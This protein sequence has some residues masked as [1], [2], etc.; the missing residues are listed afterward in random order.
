MGA[1]RRTWPCQP[2]KLLCGCCVCW[3]DPG[4]C[5]EGC[6]EL[7]C[8]FLGSL[9]VYVLL[10]TIYMYIYIYIYLMVLACIGMLQIFSVCLASASSQVSVLEHWRRPMQGFCNYRRANVRRSDCEKPTFPKLFQV[11]ST[12]QNMGAQRSNIVARSLDSMLGL[13]TTMLCLCPQKADIGWDLSVLG[14]PLISFM[15]GWICFRQEAQLEMFGTFQLLD[16]EDRHLRTLGQLI[17]GDYVM[18]G[19]RLLSMYFKTCQVPYSLRWSVLFW[20]VTCEC[21]YDMTSM[22][23]Q[24]SCLWCQHLYQASSDLCDLQDGSPPQGVRRRHTA[25]A[26]SEP[27]FAS[28][29]LDLLPPFYS[30]ENGELDFKA[31]KIIVGATW[32]HILSHI[33]GESLAWSGG[34][35]AVPGW[36]ALRSPP[37]QE[38]NG[39]LSL[40]CIGAEVQFLADLTQLI[41]R[42]LFVWF[43]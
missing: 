35:G 31:F 3:T 22:R 14:S 11:I 27:P 25:P 23:N 34:F 36:G 29:A 38:P 15:K 28:F 1:L 5:T 42:L 6:G 41:V 8:C 37:L 43:I 17:Q 13:L 7:P 9:Q 16:F 12:M 33:Q 2:S 39:P 4:S 40:W 20:N 32:R 18:K 30:N 26:G 24:F 19:I 21:E 10:L